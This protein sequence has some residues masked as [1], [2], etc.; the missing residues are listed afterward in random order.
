MKIKI[1]IKRPGKG[2]VAVKFNC[3]E[4]ELFQILKSE[5]HDRRRKIK[6]QHKDM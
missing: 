6:E 3:S 2:E 4:A 5:K 1:K